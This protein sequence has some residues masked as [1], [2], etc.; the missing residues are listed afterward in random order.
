LPAPLYLATG[1]YDVTLKSPL[2]ATIWTRRVAASESAE[3]A[4][5][6]LED[7]LAA[8]SGAGMIGYGSGTVA[9][10]LAPEVNA[11]L[12]FNVPNNGTTSA[13]A[14]IQGMFSAAVVSGNVREIYFPPGTYLITNPRNDAQITSAIVLSGL[15]RCKIYGAKG[16]KFIVSGAGAGSAAAHRLSGRRHDL[17]DE[18]D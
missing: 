16:T 3:S 2:G 7:D 13:T 4:E 18:N 15:K 17:P 11:V 9:G 12:N 8:S 5:L 10:F 14:A 1:S 6:A